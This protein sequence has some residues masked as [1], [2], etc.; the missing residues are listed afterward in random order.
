MTAKLTNSQWLQRLP[1]RWAL[2]GLLLGIVWS[3]ISGFLQGS[4]VNP[5]GGL[6]A[7]ITRVIIYVVLPLAVLGLVWGYTERAKLTRCANQSRESLLIAIQRTVARQVGKAI[8]C[9]LV[10][11]I[12]LFGV[13]IG[14]R[15]FLWDTPDHISANIV[16]VLGGVLLAV[17]VGLIVGLIFKRNL[18]ARFGDNTKP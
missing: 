6:A 13:N 18:S 14:P 4:Y 1:I 15:F 8:I 12:V 3:L 2:G 16:E 10:L 7:G 17:P 11:E 5:H 9:A